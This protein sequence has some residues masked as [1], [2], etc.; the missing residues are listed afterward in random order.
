MTLALKRAAL[1]I[2]FHMTAW[3]MVMHRCTKFGGKI[4]SDS[5]RYPLDN[6]QMHMKNDSIDYIPTSITMTQMRVQKQKKVQPLVPTP[7]PAISIQKLTHVQVDTIDAT[8]KERKDPVNRNKHKCN[9]TCHQQTNK[10]FGFF[11]YTLIVTGFYSRYGLYNNCKT[12]TGKS[13][14]NHYDN[15]KW[16]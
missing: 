6:M 4:T 7:H 1:N 10:S 5:K 8:M 2:Q 15:R 14:I 11:F 3:F 13:V 9:S 16:P 12:V